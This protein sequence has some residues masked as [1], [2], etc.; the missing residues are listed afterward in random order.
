MCP[1]WYK[2]LG[3]SW[4]GLTFMGLSSAFAISVAL[5]RSPKE[6]KAHNPYTRHAINFFLLTGILIVVFSVLYFLLGGGVNLMN[7]HPSSGASPG[8]GKWAL[9]GV[10]GCAVL[11]VIYTILAI[12]HQI[13][14]RN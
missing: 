10:G 2:T 6:E 5:N 14:N 4:L 13:K 3:T 7:P 9:F 1:I 12:I 11:G 8:L